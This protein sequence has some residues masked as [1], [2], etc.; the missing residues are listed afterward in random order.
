[1][2]GELHGHRAHGSRRAKDEDRLS[3]PKIERYRLMAA[4]FMM[5]DMRCL[6]LVARWLRRRDDR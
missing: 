3:W 4:A 2:R 1:L 6:A 5:A